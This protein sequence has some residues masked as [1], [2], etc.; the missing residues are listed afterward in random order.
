M[1]E[2]GAIKYRLEQGYTMTRYGS[3]EAMI[4]Q[5]ITDT[6][7]LLSKVENNEVLDLVSDSVCSNCD[8][9]GYTIDENGR[10][11]EHCDKC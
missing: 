3:K 7:Y 2:I 8:G 1:N 9:Y 4:E 11:K 6:E 5:L 10:R